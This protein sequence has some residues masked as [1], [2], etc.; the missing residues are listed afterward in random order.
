MGRIIFAE[1]GDSNHGPNLSGFSRKNRRGDVKAFAQRK[2]L[3]SEK[4]T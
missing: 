4:S 1:F 2:E 3:K